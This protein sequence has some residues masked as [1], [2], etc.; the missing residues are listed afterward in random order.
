LLLVLKIPPMK[1]L[2]KPGPMVGLFS[3]RAGGPGL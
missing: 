1:M 3:G 2:Q